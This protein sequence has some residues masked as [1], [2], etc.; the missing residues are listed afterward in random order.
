MRIPSLRRGPALVVVAVFSLA[1]SSLFAHDLF[2]KLAS[3]FLPADTPVRVMV[4]NG[5]FD[6]SESVL[7]RDRIA[8][9]ALAGPTG[10][11][12]LDTTAL[13]ARHDTS[14]VNLRTGAAGTYVLGLSVRPRQ[15]D[16]TA[17][18]FNEYLKA[19][20]Y[21]DVLA[22][23]T[24]AGALE[25]AGTRRYATHVKAIF[26]VGTARS[27][28]YSTVLG[29]AAE[30]VPLDNPYG[31]ARG[32]TL[33]LRCLVD[34]KPVE[35]LMVHSGGLTAQGAAFHGTAVRTG[36]DGM[37]GIPLGHAGRWYVKFSK[38]RPSSTA[39]VNYES[40]RT[41]LTFEVR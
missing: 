11:T 10:T 6:K 41:S 30:I 27:G 26:Q 25:Q 12:A 16:Y 33:R 22:E 18:D 31:L 13:T 24:R 21:D 40:E 34:G 8:G 37:A 9:I 5:T 28:A 19:D 29:H 14:F 23:R 38:M 20:G 17:T 3:F 4:L 2:L 39:G 15:V 7:A 1:A 36:V 32:G 35:G